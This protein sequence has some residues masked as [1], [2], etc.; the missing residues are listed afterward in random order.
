VPG[1]RSRRRDEELSLLAIRVGDPAR[2]EQVMAE[3]LDA[4]AIG[5]EEREEGSGRLLL[6]YAGAAAI[7]RVREAAELAVAGAGEIQGPSAVPAR[8]W[9]NAWRA[10]H[11]AVEISPRLVVRP[12]F[13]PAPARAGQ[14]SLV[15]EPGQAFGTGAHGST[16]LGLELLDALAERGALMG[17]VL[18]VGT[19]SGVLALAALLLG[20]ERAV[21]CDLDPLAAHAARDNARRNGLDRRLH[22]FTGSLDALAPCRFDV[23]VANLLRSELE[24]CLPGIGLRARGPVL[25]SGLLEDEAERAEAALAAAG[26]R[27]VARRTI[28][29]DRGDAWLGLSCSR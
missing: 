18:D 16:R 20:A 19:G 1:D 3:V 26:L 12:S 4:G 17:R 9:A 6:V 11:A 27:V 29:D 7:E 24:P 22:V 21:G 13:V 5:L 10:S 23:V 14:R 15:I 8:D 25:V 28:R 2:A